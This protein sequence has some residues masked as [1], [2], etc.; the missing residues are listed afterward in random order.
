MHEPNAAL[1]DA[2]ALVAGLLVAR[3]ALLILLGRHRWAA[4]LARW[5][6]RGVIA[7]LLVPVL[8]LASLAAGGGERQA[9]LVVAALG[10]VVA[11]VLV[12]L[13]DGVLTARPRPAK[14]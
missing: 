10:I 8:R 14:T 13:I 5:L 6:R 3:Y 12:L 2:A 9:L 7:A 1:A 4:W 11:G